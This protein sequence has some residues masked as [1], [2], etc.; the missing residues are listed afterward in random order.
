MPSQIRNSGT[1]ARLGIAR[2]AWMVGS[3]SSKPARLI[4]A[5]SP[6]TVAVTA[7][8]KN[9]WASRASVIPR[10]FHSEPSRTDSCR[11]RATALAGGNTCASIQ[12][13]RGA[14]SQRRRARAGRT[15]PNAMDRHVRFIGSIECAAGLGPEAPP[16]G[17]ASRASG[18]GLRLNDLLCEARI[19]ISVHRCRNVRSG[20]DMPAFQQHLSGLQE[21]F[22]QAIIWNSHIEVGAFA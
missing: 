22:A 13:R 10:W 12:P 3:K 9:P 1:Q 6:K 15:S 21:R 7:P 18:F 5:T 17:A 8:A 2:K 19:H 4:P 20:T 16:C 11:Y 14:I